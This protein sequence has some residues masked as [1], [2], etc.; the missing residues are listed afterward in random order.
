MVVVWVLVG[1]VVSG[2]DR[3]EGATGIDEARVSRCTSVPS[4]FLSATSQ[5]ATTGRRSMPDIWC[6]NVFLEVGPSVNYQHKQT[7]RGA[8]KGYVESIPLG[9]PNNTTGSI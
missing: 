7:M 1:V 9:R 3:Y 5:P 2:G 8:S 6:T 4:L